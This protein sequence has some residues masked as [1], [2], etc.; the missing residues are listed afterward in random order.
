M[1]TISCRPS[2][3][4]TGRPDEDAGQTIAL[5]KQAGI[6]YVLI[7]LKTPSVDRTPE[8]TLTAKF[9]NLLNTVSLHPGAKILYTDH[10]VER[11]DG[12]I[13]MMF[14]GRKIRAANDLAGKRAVKQGSIALFE[15]L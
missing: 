3:P 5:M 2:I 8:K 14:E 6:K 15:I 12:P 10:M 1:R 9:Y 7:S 11:D 4:C 13:E